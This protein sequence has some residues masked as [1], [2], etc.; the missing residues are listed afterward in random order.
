MRILGSLNVN[1]T[2]LLSIISTFKDIPD[3]SQQCVLERQTDIF[4]SI[5]SA[6][7]DDLV[8]ISCAVSEII[9]Y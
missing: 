1:F 4:E 7:F 2:D 9:R 6:T 5:S 8:C 3:H